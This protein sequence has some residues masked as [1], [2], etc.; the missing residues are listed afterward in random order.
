MNDRKLS[1]WAHCATVTMEPPHADCPDCALPVRLEG[2]RF[3]SH[4]PTTKHGDGR[5]CPGGGKP[6]P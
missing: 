5:R 3:V 1:G 2:G 6:P 4:P